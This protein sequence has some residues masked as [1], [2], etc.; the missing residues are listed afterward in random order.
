MDAVQLVVHIEP[1]CRKHTLKEDKEKR[2]EKY[3]PWAKQT[4]NDDSRWVLKSLTPSL[5][6]DSG[7]WTPSQGFDYKP[8][9]FDD[10]RNSHSSK[11]NKH[12]IEPVPIPLLNIEEADFLNRTEKLLR[13]DHKWKTLVAQQ[14]PLSR[15]SSPCP[16]NSQTRSLEQ[17]ETATED[18]MDIRDFSKRP[19]NNLRPPKTAQETQSNPSKFDSSSRMPRLCSDES[20]SHGHS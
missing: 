3:R 4:D 13:T 5:S 18:D 1:K 17:L 6:S 9:N 19:T 2:T 14:V 16:I 10:P 7:A 12:P 11:E 15:T 20:C 8:K